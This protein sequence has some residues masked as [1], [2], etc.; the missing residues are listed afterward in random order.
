[1][2]SSCATPRSWLALSEQ[3]TLEP[4][5]SRSSKRVQRWPP[6]MPDP[7]ALEPEEPPA[8]DLLLK[9]VEPEVPGELELPRP[10]DEPVLEGGAPDGPVPAPPPKPPETGLV[11]TPGP[12]VPP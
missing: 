1:M 2:A 8:P 11:G 12:P 3:P 6:L 7:P 4:L 5:R 9:P 10:V